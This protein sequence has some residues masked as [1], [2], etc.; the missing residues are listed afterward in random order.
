MPPGSARRLV[1]SC[2]PTPRGISLP[3]PRRPVLVTRPEPGAAET[4]ARLRVRRYAPIVAPVLTIIPQVIAPSADVQA[5]L[6]TSAN[7]IVPGLPD[8]PVFAVGDATAA[9]ARAAGMS[10]VRSAGRDAAALAEL[11]MRECRPQFGPLLLA[12]GEGHGLALAAQLRRAGFRV[13][14]VV[15]YGARPVR[16]LPANAQEFIATGRGHALFFSPETAHVFVRI[17]RRTGFGGG[18]A[19]IEALAISAATAAGLA[20][21]NWARIR[22]AAHPNQDALL[23]LL[24]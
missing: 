14:R 11:V 17:C 8:R 6:L 1:R 18:V 24:P 19:G 2:G 22:I 23:A 15:A 10:T 20:A 12:S 3:S 16:A 21:L 9:R 7:A 5:I 4:A 13:R